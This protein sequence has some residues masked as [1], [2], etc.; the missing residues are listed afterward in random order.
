MNAP[1]QP[2]T[3]ELLDL[4][5]WARAT[6]SLFPAH[7]LK[8]ARM[9]ELLGNYAVL[10]ARVAELENPFRAADDIDWAH[11]DQFIPQSGHGRFWKAVF[12]EL[13]AALSHAGPVARDGER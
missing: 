1:S 3:D 9:A 2:T 6:E 8:Y 13:R 12:A 5:E 10:K 11:L 4:A 7:T